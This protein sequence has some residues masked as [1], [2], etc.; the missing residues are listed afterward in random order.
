MLAGRG[1]LPG[2]AVGDLQA[3]V[4]ADEGDQA[5]EPPGEAR[6][7]CLQAKRVEETRQRRAEGTAKASGRGGDAVDGAQNRARGGRV[8]QED[9]V[10]RVGQGRECALPDNQHVD[11]RHSQAVGEKHKVWRDEV[12]GEV[13]E[14]HHAESSKRAETLGDGSNDDVVGEEGVESLHGH[15]DTNRLGAETKPV[16]EFERQLSLGVTSR[17]G[18]EE[19]G[20]ELIVSHGVATSIC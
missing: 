10:A 18:A 8:G 13:R 9:G 7:T 20:E 3:E 17:R 14:G 2:S 6:V 16:D 19:D 1:V 12:E 5:A 11:G 4:G 15:D